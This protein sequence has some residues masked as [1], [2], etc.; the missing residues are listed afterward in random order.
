[1]A[2]DKIV[3][4]GA[5]DTK[6]TAIADAIRG[7]TGKT[8]EMTLDQ[9]VTEIAG[10]QIGGGGDISA[11]LSLLDKSCTEINLP[12][13]VTIG[14]FG[15]SIDRLCTYN[16]NLLSACFPDLENLYSQYCFADCSNL[17]SLQ[18][19]KLSSELP[20]YMCENCSKLKEMRLPSLKSNSGSAQFRG[21]SSL[22]LVEFG[23]VGRL[24]AFPRVG[25]YM[26]TN[27]VSLKTLI[28]RNPNQVWS[29]FAQNA[30][31]NT[32]FAVGGT[33]GTVYCSQALIEQY[34]TATNWSTLYAAGTCNFVAIE[35]SEYE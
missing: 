30:F 21:C 10:I 13:V 32:P 7:K 5:L 33:G 34:Q 1:M 16:N 11:F 35:G 14:L 3:D 22:E 28:F 9:M 8:E 25:S 19:Q 26:F 15:A 29:L 12:G 17:Q 24:G 31:D 20:N 4:S 2:Y 6:L 27:C 18:L 23:A